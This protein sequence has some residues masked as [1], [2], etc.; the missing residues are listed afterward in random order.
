MSHKI[1]KFNTRS[2]KNNITVF[3]VFNNNS[4]KSHKN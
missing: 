1:C 4:H 3:K 2:N